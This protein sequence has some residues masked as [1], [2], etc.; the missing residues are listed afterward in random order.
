VQDCDTYSE[1]PYAVSN[2]VSADPPPP[3][4]PEPK[5]TSHAKH[6]PAFEVRG[7][8]YRILGVELTA[9]AGLEASRAQVL[10]S[11]IGPAMSKWPTEKH[12]ASWLGLAPHK[13][14]SGGKVVRSKPLK[15]PAA[16]L[17]ATAHKLARI[18]YSILKQRTPYQPQSQETSDQHVR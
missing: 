13:D 3:L 1:Q 4:G 18:L 5:P 16:A 2:P 10:V 7:N 17:T 9:G 14:I 15:G 8:W 6:A 12:F 11:E